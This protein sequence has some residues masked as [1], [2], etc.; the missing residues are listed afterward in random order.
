MPFDTI[1]KI[2]GDGI[3]EEG[4]SAIPDWLCKIQNA[5]V[6]TLYYNVPMTETVT[7]RL[8]DDLVRKV[9]AAVKRGA[10]PSRSEALRTILEEYLSDHPEL[11]LE[12]SA[13]ELLGEK[14]SD[15]EL[16]RLG[17]KIFSG[18]SVAKL[19]AEGRGR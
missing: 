7:A 18:S 6:I 9:D 13:Q 8:P 11:F 19:V 14:L 5:Y 15:Q 2:D 10:F 12:T 16:E 1:G 3:G 4:R 17:A